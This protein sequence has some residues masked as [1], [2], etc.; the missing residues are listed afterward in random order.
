MLS[1]FRVV[2]LLSLV[3]PLSADGL[4]P[5]LTGAQNAAAARIIRGFKTNPKGPFLRIRWF[6]NDGTVHPPSPPP[7]SDRGGGV[8]H[9]ELS[10]QA[11]SLRQWNIDAGTILTGLP[12]TELFDVARDHH[13]MRE[14]VLERYLVDIDGGWIYRRANAYRGTRQ[15]EDEEEAGRNFLIRLLSDPQW[16]GRHYFLANQV[17]SVVPHGIPDSLVKRIRTLATV[18]ADQEP[19][20]QPLRAKI[21]SAPDNS[22]LAA[23]E[24]FARVN[25]TS[26]TVS[27]LLAEL[28]ARMREERAGNNVAARLPVLEQS[29]RDPG[30]RSIV[31]TFAGALREGSDSARLFSAGAA[32]TVE[33]EKLVT[34]SSN[35]N[36]NLE[37]LDFNLLVQETAF[38]SKVPM[39]SATR[40]ELLRHLRDHLR[41]SVGAGLLSSRQYASLE[42]EIATLEAVKEVNAHTWYNG[43]RYLAR[44]SEWIR[45]TA[46]R[47]F[48]PVSRL[49]SG[50]EPAARSLVDHLI[51]GSV[52]LPL[53]SH[54]ERLV[55]DANKSV[56]IRH[57]ILG[58]PSA[59]VVGLNPGMA[60]GRLDLIA[61]NRPA[62]GS[63]DPRGIYVIP[64]TVSDLKPMAGI[65]SLDSGNM[66]SHTQLLAANLGIP[67]ATVPSSLLPVLEKSRGREVFF[68]VTPKGVVVLRDRV[69]LSEAERKLLERPVVKKRIMLDTSRVNLAETRLVTLAEIGTRD[70]GVISGPKAANLGQLAQYFPGEVAPGLVIPFGVYWEHINRVL[71]GDR[72]PLS[73]QISSAYAQ[74]DRM[75]K[76]GAASGDV[77]RFIYPKLAYFR[78][79]IRSMPLLPSFEKMLADRARRLFGEDG[80]YGVFVRSD[81]NAED[82]PQFTGAG[83]NLTVPN[84]VGM[85]NILAALREVWASPFSERAYAWRSRILDG[86]DRVYPSVI[87]MR[88]VASEKSGVIATVNL[89]TWNTREST[90]NTSEGVSAVVDGGVAESLLLLPDGGV[91]L[92]QEARGPFRRQLAPGGGFVNV[93]VSGDDTVLKPEDIACVRKLVE[94]V[95]AKYPAARTERGDLLPWDIEFGF[96]NGNLRLFQ[97]RPLVRSQEYKMLE[98]LASIDGAGDRNGSV[99]LDEGLR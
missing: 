87:L 42:R 8:Q 85:K 3:V 86:G 5:P 95:K 82:L 61:P 70:S 4:L 64:E 88:A 73:K 72:E 27:N 78:K 77:E 84:R 24:Q 52:A 28:Q 92:L 29:L 51:R 34:S 9:A 21:H 32:L 40:L 68:A 43:I 69:N 10:P 20:F 60:S 93:P 46:A 6:C 76:A 98:L 89:E 79:R 45:A 13:R 37:L 48:G 97:I 7:C 18:I 96:E 57:S 22:D 83:L 47:D 53:A 63:V 54:L 26:P 71:P 11:L 50:F 16:V 65:L 15:V 67:N 12:F 31:D 58:V 17:V 1:L 94:E 90:V 2:A 80:S 49:Y 38:H 19:R 35:G 39:Q 33:I 56:G 14:L 62:G 66:L 74:A 99:R 25:T 44:A 59:G 55:D 81:T 91:K 75:R 30:L 41:Y 23:V 36:R